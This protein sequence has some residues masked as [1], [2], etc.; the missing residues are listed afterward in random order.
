MSRRNN[1]RIKVKKSVDKK[2][3]ANT[4]N[5]IHPKNLT[6]ENPRGGIRL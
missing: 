6:I 4:A 2:I 5:K 1:R 3:F